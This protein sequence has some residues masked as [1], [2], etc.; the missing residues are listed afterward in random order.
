MLCLESTG[1]I[2]IQ[3][4]TYIDV[5]H[6]IPGLPQYNEDILLLAV[7][8][9]KYREQVP[10]QL[11]KLVIDHLVLTMTTEELQQTDETW[12]HVHLSTVLSK[13]NTVESP[14]IPMYHLKGVKGKINMTQKE[15]I[16]PFM[17]MIVKGAQQ[18]NWC[19]IYLNDIIVFSKTPKKHL[20]DNAFK[21]CD[22]LLS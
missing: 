15:V 22:V 7:L 12:K 3:S 13:R 11:G 20:I 10:V 8:D 18:L 21:M 17:T 19:L 9:H 2:S 4:K 16:S 6:I 14:G 1:G 5:S